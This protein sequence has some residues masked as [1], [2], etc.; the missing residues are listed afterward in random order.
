MRIHWMMVRE[1]FV[2]AGTFKRTSQD[3]QR[4][5]TLDEKREQLGHEEGKTK[6]QCNVASY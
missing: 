1:E 3:G 6:L 5:K 4:C 2:A